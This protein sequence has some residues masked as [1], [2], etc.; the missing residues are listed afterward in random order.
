LPELI[1][2]CGVTAD[3]YIEAR[4]AIPAGQLLELP[5]ADLEADKLGSVQ[6]GSSTQAFACTPLHVRVYLRSLCCLLQKLYRFFGWGAVP[7]QLFDYA[8]GA[9]AAFQPLLCACLIG[10]NRLT[11]LWL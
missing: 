4:D 9:I 8:G 10:R 1:S 11:P 5:Y 6:V 7:A 2:S 3:R